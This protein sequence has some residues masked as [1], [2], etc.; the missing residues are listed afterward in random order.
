MSQRSVAAVSVCVLVTALF[1]A[2]SAAA[3]G[4]PAAA[5]PP[6]DFV[7]GS[8]KTGPPASPDSAANATEFS[9]SAHKDLDGRV[10]GHVN[11]RSITFLGPESNGH[12]HVLCLDVRGNR[13]LIAG[14]FR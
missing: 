6:Q 3:G 12:G 2:G 1:G 5:D 10:W 13:A 9:V 14:T 8:G 4:A 7:V 11:E